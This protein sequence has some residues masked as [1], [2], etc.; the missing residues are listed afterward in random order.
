MLKCLRCATTAALTS[1][2]SELR[3]RSR[4]LGL[5]LPRKVEVM[6]VRTC[7]LSLELAASRSAHAR[8]DSVKPLPTE[9]VPRASEASQ[10][11]NLLGGKVRVTQ[12]YILI[13]SFNLE[14]L[15]VGCTDTRTCQPAAAASRSNPRR[16]APHDRPESE[17]E[18]VPLRLV[19]F[20][21]RHAR[22]RASYRRYRAPGVD[23]GCDSPTALAPAEANRI[24]LWL[25]L[26]RG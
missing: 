20:V 7:A 13:W 24:L 14:A 4:S 18:S 15:R 10:S 12:N 17:R 16:R 9:G 23:G 1:G 11:A 25:G 6:C 19:R 3:S 22:P 8:P 2:L 21:S 5:S 26:G